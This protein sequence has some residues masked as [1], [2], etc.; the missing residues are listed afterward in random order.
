MIGSLDEKIN[1]E[2][3]MKNLFLVPISCLVETMGI[4][5]KISWRL[6]FK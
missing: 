6:D 5:T 2:I 3:N 1:G 4:E